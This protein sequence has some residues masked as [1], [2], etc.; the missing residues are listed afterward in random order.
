MAK[1]RIAPLVKLARF[2]NR[3]LLCEVSEEVIEMST[4]C[5]ESTLQEFE[6]CLHRELRGGLEHGFFDLVI[7]CELTKGR[8]R[9]LTLSA[10]KSHL[11]VIPEEDLRS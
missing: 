9:Q 11:F 8:K 6:R 3:I 4:K 2:A 5:S 1:S 10:G 7:S